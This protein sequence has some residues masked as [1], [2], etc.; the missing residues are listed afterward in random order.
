MADFRGANGE[1]P[2]SWA[3][4]CWS[5]FIDDEEQLRCAINY[6]R[7]HPEKEGLERREWGFVRE[8]PV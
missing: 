4:G 5:V 3:E 2:T 7:R 1:Y 6:V 8:Y